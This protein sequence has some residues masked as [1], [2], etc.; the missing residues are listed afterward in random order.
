[1][2]ALP[3]P[4]VS[5][6]PDWHYV[7]QEFYHAYRF[8]SAGGS[9]E[10]RRHLREVQ[11]RISRCVGADPEITFQPPVTKPVCAHLGRALDN[12]ENERSQTF[13]RA[14]AKIADLLVWQYGYDK[15]PRSLEKKY[16][17]AELMGPRGPVICE[18]LILGLV[19]FAPKCSYPAHSHQDITESYLCL[20][21]MISENHAGVYLPG[22]MILNQAGR[23]H[24]I[25]TS[26]TEPVLLTYAWVG[27][28][29][30][31]HGFEMTFSRGRVTTT[32]QS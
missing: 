32:S 11:R 12:G 4:R 14:L 24:A 8:G 27:A 10:I 7:L 16:A 15:M 18:D 20:S 17:Y 31:L 5:D 30:V 22:S 3:E 21:G 6:H 26:D 9:A 13:I 28:P 25:T 23:E 19:L 29:S 1:M 2:S